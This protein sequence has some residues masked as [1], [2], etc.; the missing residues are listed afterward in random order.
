MS[1]QRNEEKTG[2]TQFQGSPEGAITPPPPFAPEN[3]LTPPPFVD[4][5][6]TVPTKLEK[7]LRQDACLVQIYPLGQ[8]LGTRYPLV[9]KSLLIGRENE[10]AICIDDPSV[11][12]RHAE[13]R[14]GTAGHFLIDLRSTNGTFVNDRPATSYKLSD[15]D[16]IRIGTRIFRYLAG[17]NIEMLYH[18]EIYR[19][20][21]VDALTG[22][23]N[24]RYFLE[25]LDRELAR[26]HTHRRP[27]ALVMLDID[28]FKAINDKL[29]HLAGDYALRELA[30]CLQPLVRKEELLARYG[31]EEFALVLPDVGRDEALR[32]AEAMRETILRHPL[33]YAGVPFPVT[34][35]LGVAAC[36]PEKQL[37]VDDLVRQADAKLY[38]A[39]NAG[40]NC[41][42]G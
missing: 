42:R 15:G 1:E 13:I 22:V 20:T 19:L 4:T 14:P 12:R 29:G 9:E 7:D 3:G 35:S 27:L 8:G 18:E 30:L 41:V 40:R 37:E 31:G 23:H 26:A 5:L 39:K 6:S 36:L 16:Y 33:N 11:S 10:C 28:H 32:R 24:K 21:I 2:S 25:F 38:E 34:I 17:N